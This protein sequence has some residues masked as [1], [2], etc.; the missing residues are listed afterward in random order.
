MWYFEFGMTEQFASSCK[1]L[2]QELEIEV[3]PSFSFSQTQTQTNKV[4]VLHSK[5]E[6]MSQSQP[7]S[8][9]FRFRSSPIPISWR[10]QWMMTRRD[11][12]RWD[13]MR[14]EEMRFSSSFIR[15]CLLSFY[16]LAHNH[17]TYLKSPLLSFSFFFFGKVWRRPTWSPSRLIS[18][19]LSSTQHSIH[20]RRHKH[21]GRPSLPE[22][23]QEAEAEAEA[24]AERGAKPNCKPVDSRPRL[25]NNKPRCKK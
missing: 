14:W 4:C 19:R 24:G 18:P 10:W 16:I 22:T 3:S 13:E 11:G 12:M 23:G 21:V 5:R 1:N 6:Q 15:K 20:S 17:K 9:H 8:T 25:V 7:S 2:H